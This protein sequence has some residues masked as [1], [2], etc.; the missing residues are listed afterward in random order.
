MYFCRKINIFNKIFHFDIINGKIWLQCNN[1]EHEV[2]DE[3]MAQGVNN[4]DIVLGLVPPYARQ[5]TGFA[6]A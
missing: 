4:E 6:V 3:L 1:T 2:V 5:F